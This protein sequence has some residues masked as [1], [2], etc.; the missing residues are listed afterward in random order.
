MKVNKF[1]S[2]NKK[3]N[4]GDYVIAGVNENDNDLIFHPK[5]IEYKKYME[6]TPGKLKTTI[7]NYAVIK[8]YTIPENIK[9]FFNDAGFA[10]LSYAPIRLATPEEIER[11]NIEIDANKYNI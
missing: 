4:I 5:Y 3:F 6:T 2:F 9:S 8:Y 11:L 1:D 10:F 7:A